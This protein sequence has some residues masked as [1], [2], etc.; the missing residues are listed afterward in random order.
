MTLRGSPLLAR[1]AAAL[2]AVG[3]VS[4]C[5]SRPA[6]PLVA[7]A[8]D[9]QFA[10]AEIADLFAKETGNRVELTFGSSGVLARQIQDGAPFELFL[11]A[12]E[13]FVDRLTRAGRTRDDGVLYAIGRIVLFAPPGSLVVPAE[14]LD[15]LGRRIARGQ[16]TRFAIANLSLIHI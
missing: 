1:A 15:G 9:L 5:S 7:A 14:G 8:S 6:A 3:I 11:S 10:L 2:A 13:A 4:A 12:D 16:V